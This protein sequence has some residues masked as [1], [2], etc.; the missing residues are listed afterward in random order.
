MLVVANIRDVKLM[1]TFFLS[2]ILIWFCFGIIVDS[3]IDEV[4]V[5][6]SIFRLFFVCLTLFVVKFVLLFSEMFVVVCGQSR[7]PF[8]SGKFLMVH[9]WFR[10]CCFDFLAVIYCSFFFCD[11]CSSWLLCFVADCFFVYMICM[12]FV[13]LGFL[14]SVADCFSCS[15]TG[16]FF[17]LL[18]FYFQCFS[19]IFIVFMFHH[20]WKRTRLLSQK[21]ED[22]SYQTT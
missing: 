21:R 3:V 13:Y 7:F 8:S 2:T 14:C 16:F 5:G 22:T 19:V 18:V 11:G 12:N 6:V 17:V 1:S 20:K 10:G 9:F 15:V 4:C